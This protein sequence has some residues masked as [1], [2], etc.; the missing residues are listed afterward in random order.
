MY[1]Y[2]CT[3]NNNQKRKNNVDAILDAV[4]EGLVVVSTAMHILHE[5]SVYSVTSKEWFLNRFC[6]TIISL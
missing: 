2:P 3:F 1:K 6:S 4:E 5:N